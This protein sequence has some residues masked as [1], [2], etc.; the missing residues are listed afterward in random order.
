MPAAKS[1]SPIR[2][3]RMRLTRLSPALA[4]LV[5]PASTG[6]S[7]GFVSVKITPQYDEGEAIQQKNA[8]GDFCINEKGEVV[9]EGADAEIQF[10]GVS[11]DYLALITGFQTVVDFTAAAT[12]LR[13]SGGIPV[14]DGYALEVWTGVAG[15][16]GTAWGYLLLPALKGGRIGEFTIQNGA[17]TFTVTSSAQ[18]N[19]GWGV[20]PYDVVAVDAQGVA[21]P[22]LTALDTK[23]FV[24]LD[25]VTVAPPAATDGLIALAA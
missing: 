6:V 2:G 12:G 8:N 9:L 10:C 21:G 15:Q 7:E 23:D 20:G 25:L 4:P 14:T 22:L 11:P 1:W 5:G 24:H 13:L 19:P 3:K 18:E 16:K 17:A